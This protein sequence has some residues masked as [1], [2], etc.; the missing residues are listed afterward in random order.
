MASEERT[1][2]RQL[3]C[4]L[5][6]KKKKYFQISNKH[7]KPKTVNIYDDMIVT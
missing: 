2:N 1:S 6:K 5:T 4:Y 3:I 7:E